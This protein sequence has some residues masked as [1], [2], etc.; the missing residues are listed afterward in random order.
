ML[1]GDADVERPVRKR[2]AED[3]EAGAPGHGRGHG[4]YAVVFG[5]LLHEALAE[6]FRVGW[7]G[8]FRFG[9]LSG[10]DVEFRH[11]VT[12]VA[13]GFRRGVTFAF[14]GHDVNQDR[15]RLGVANLPQRRH[16][17]VQVVTVDGAD[18]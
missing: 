18:I 5:G 13:G 4:D 6:D 10:R 15:A 14:S 1:F 16:Q 9:L 7:R 8:R 3:V 12:F 17:V 11:R 2:L